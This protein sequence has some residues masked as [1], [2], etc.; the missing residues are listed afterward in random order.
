MFEQAATAAGKDLTVASF[1]KG[2]RAS[3]TSSSGSG[4]KGSFGPNKFD[5][6]DEIRSVKYQPSC[7]CW[8]P[9]SDYFPVKF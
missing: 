7:N 3:R 9:T 6:P 8:V 2:C 4:G 1:V 5:A